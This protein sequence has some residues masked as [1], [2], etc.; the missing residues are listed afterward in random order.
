MKLKLSL[1]ALVVLVNI[2]SC[3]SG[4][5]FKSND[6]DMKTLRDSASY[7]VGYD[8]GQSFKMQNFDPDLQKLIPGLM[9]GFAG[10][11]CLLDKNALRQV[12][13][14]Y[15]TQLQQKLAKENQ[16]KG[17]AFLENNKNKDG[18]KV[19]PSGLQYKVIKEGNG[20][21]PTL[22]DKVRVNYK[23]KLIDGTE[24]DSSFKRNEPAVLELGNVIDGWKE[25]IQLMTVGSQYEL[26]IPSELGYGERGGGS[27]G[28]G[29]VLIFEVELLEIVK[30]QPQ[31]PG[32]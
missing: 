24:F 14:A 2:L 26:Y 28:P 19:L 31:T 10:D 17:K 25:G 16:D 21:K 20:A 18:V 30:D 8:I 5:S 3:Q 11:T 32:Q 1:L 23:G 7:A 6:V 15:H 22:S 29:S 27:I 4:E 13:I 12:A 9:A